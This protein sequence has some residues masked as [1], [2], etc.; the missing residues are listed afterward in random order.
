MH[1]SV[2]DIGRSDAS[3]L[4]QDLA[5]PL[6]LVG[7]GAETP[8]RNDRTAGFPQAVSGFKHDV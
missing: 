6:P 5:A 8:C 4:W 3:D 1:T 2:A 7:R